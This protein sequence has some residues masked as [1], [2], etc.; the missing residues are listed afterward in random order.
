MTIQVPHVEFSPE[1]RDLWQRV[2]DLWALSK[3]RDEGRIRSS[4]HPDYVGWDMSAALSHDRD[5]AV[6]SV[7]G[8]SET[9]KGVKQ[10]NKQRGQILT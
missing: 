4:I 1:Q 8:V 5:A 2:T 10:A 7:S 9:S 6:R 3:E